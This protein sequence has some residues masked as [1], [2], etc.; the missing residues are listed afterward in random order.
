MSPIRYISSL[1][2]FAVLLGTIPPVAAQES[3]DPAPAP[4]SLERTREAFREAI[5]RIWVPR[6]RLTDGP[7]VH[8]AFRDVVDSPS[9]ATVSVRSSGK[10]LALGGIV[11]PDGW[12]LTKASQLKEPVTV[13]LKDKREL[14]ARVVGIDRDSDLAMLKVAA[15]DL[16]SLPLDEEIAAQAGAW[17][18]TPGLERDPVAIG[19]VSVAPRKIPHRAGI[20]GIQLEDPPDGENRGALV[21]KVYEDTGAER[22]G[23][24]VNDVVI[25]VNGQAVKSRLALIREVRRYSPGDEIEIEVRR[26]EQKVAL[27][28]TLTG[29]VKQMFPQSRSQ[30]QNSLGGKLSQRRFGFP[31]ALQHDSVLEPTECGGPLVDLDGRVIG[32]NIARAGRTESYAIPTKTIL[33]LMYKLMSGKQAP[34]PVEDPAG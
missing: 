31:T 17:V 19:V 18:A 24:L 14:D 9:S 16:P 6:H 32:F 33:P 27:T 21:V 34:E 28:A 25:G 8:A 1:A 13:R 11:G 7:F 29:R 12:I 20:L 23:V 30:Y 22:A 5:E 3:D 26:G 4:P 10:R 15:K 2:L